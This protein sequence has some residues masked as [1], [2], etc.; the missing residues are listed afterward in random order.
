LRAFFDLRILSSTAFLAL[1]R[2]SSFSFS[3]FALFF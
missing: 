2:A 3:S 1:W